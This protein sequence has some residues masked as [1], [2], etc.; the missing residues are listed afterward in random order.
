[1]KQLQKPPVS[2][3]GLGTVE[4]QSNAQ[5]SIATAGGEGTLDYAG[6]N[7]SVQGKSVWNANLPPKIRIDN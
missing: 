1:M 2:K 7:G 4:A 5:A 6:E 3:L